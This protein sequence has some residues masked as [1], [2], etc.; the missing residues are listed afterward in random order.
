MRK[1]REVTRLKRR[2]EALERQVEDEQEKREALEDKLERLKSLWK[3]DHSN[4]AD[5]SEK[6]EGLVPVKVVA[7]F[8]RDAIEDADER[9]GLARDDIVLLRDASGAGRSTARRLADVDP[10]VVLRNGNLSDAADEVLFE[11]EVPVAPAE[12][13]TVQVV[14]ELAIARE[15]EVEAA[16]ADWERRAEERKKERKTEMV[17]QIISE[18]RADRPAS[19]EN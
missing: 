19:G 8:T 18:H 1:D 10:R 11:N 12:M 5:V 9:F 16:V 4:F 13:V 6:Q 14:D 15:R 7:Q 2:N 3:L 17:D